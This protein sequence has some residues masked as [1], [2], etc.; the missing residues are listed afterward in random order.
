MFVDYA[1]FIF[2][3][4]HLTNISK[5]G[6]AAVDLWNNCKLN[7]EKICDSSLVGTLSRGGDSC[8][9]HTVLGRADGSTIAGHVVGDMVSANL[10]IMFSR[11]LGRC[12]DLGETVVRLMQVIF[13]TAEIVIGDCGGFTFDREMDHGT[14]FP[15]LVVK[16]SSKE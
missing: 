5:Y 15:E 4:V 8:H 1:S 11:S 10:W 13:T 3:T 2:R 16:E 12:F 14:G 6:E 9:L 7:T